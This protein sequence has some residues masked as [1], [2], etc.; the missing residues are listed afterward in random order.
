MKPNKE[1]EDLWR[2]APV[3]LPKCPKDESLACLVYRSG[4]YE[5]LCWNEYYQCW[6]DADG[7][8][9]AFKKET[10]LN[11]I[12]LEEEADNDNFKRF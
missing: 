7:D 2:H 4:F 9:F 3:Q 1:L 5:V 8:D 10:E 11:W 6:D 12:P